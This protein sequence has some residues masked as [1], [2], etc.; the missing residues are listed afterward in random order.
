MQEVSG[1]VPRST[2]H[3]AALDA[4]IR[5]LAAQSSRRLASCVG[6]Y[7]GR[8]KEGGHAA[9]ARRQRDAPATWS[10]NSRRS[11]PAQCSARGSCRLTS[12][13][14]IK[15]TCR[16]SRLAARPPQ[17]RRVCGRGAASKTDSHHLDPVGGQST[18]NASQP[19]DR[20]LDR[21]SSEPDIKQ[22]S[23]LCRPVP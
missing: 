12:H 8:R 2:P 14:V 7:R 20:R 3:S 15:N 17:R 18:I 22:T 9:V 13:P 21:E 4:L 10:G 1:A 5:R 19:S 16:L 23:K 11:K 6:Q